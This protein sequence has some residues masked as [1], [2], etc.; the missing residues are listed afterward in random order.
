MASGKSE[1]ESLSGPRKTNAQQRTQDMEQSSMYV[2]FMFIRM[3]E[4]PFNTTGNGVL[5][6]YPVSLSILE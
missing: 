5:N 4:Y 2:C 3:A 1:Q 6:A